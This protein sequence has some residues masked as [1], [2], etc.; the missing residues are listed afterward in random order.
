MCSLKKL[1][2][3]LVFAG[4]I[5]LPIGLY[6]QDTDQQS[7]ET[8]SLENMSTDQT[9]TTDQQGT[10]SSMGSYSTSEL[11]KG[12]AALDETPDDNLKTE[13]EGIAETQ[14]RDFQTKLGLND[15]SFGEI[16]EAITNY[17]DEGWEARVKLAQ[18]AGN[19]DAYNKN[20]ADLAYLRVDLA[21]QIKDELGDAGESQWSTHAVD[22]WTSLDKA[23]YELK[24]REAGISTG[25]TGET[26][27]MDQNQN[28]NQNQMNME[29][30]RQ[31]MNEDQQNIDQ[32]QNNTDESQGG[33]D[34]NNTDQ[35]ENTTDQDESTD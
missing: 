26:P 30:D 6:G 23:D 17:L 27:G 4:I 22:F 5:A 31:N 10:E 34:Q 7:T 14:A 1:M 8:D 15:D 32:N 24:A 11:D 12:L 2:M 29:N 19:P 28:E 25:T 33:T 18:G 16:K 3:S 35:E 20:S 13:F 9:G 21:E